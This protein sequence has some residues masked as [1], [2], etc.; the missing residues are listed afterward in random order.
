MTFLSLRLILLVTICLTKKCAKNLSLTYGNTYENILLKIQTTSILQIHVLK[1]AILFETAGPNSSNS[2]FT[3]F[4]V[5]SEE[6]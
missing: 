6:S 5:S 1:L 4:S 2:V 3:C